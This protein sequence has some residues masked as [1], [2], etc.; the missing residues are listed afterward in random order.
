MCEIADLVQLAYDDLLK[1]ED[2][3][4]FDV[5]MDC[6]L[7]VDS[8]G[9][10][11]EGCLAGAVLYCERVVELVPGKDLSVYE[12]ENCGKYMFLDHVRRIMPLDGV[13]RYLIPIDRDERKKLFD[14]E[15]K[16]EE[17]DYHKDAD[18]FKRY[19][20]ELIELLKEIGI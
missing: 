12:L 14:L 20:L 8:E 10:K 15:V 5:N 6:W 9:K 13:E 2:D 16:Y 4:N 19:L 7:E 18:E 11:C 1:V 17:A 3:E